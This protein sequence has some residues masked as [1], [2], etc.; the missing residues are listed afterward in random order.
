MKLGAGKFYVSRDGFV[1]CCYKIDPS[2]EAHAFAHCIRVTDQRE[3]YFYE[4]GRYDSKGERE[5]TLVK[6]I[7]INPDV[8]TPERDPGRAS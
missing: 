7:T 6:R 2:A 5:H 3:E 8:K 4:D 1:W